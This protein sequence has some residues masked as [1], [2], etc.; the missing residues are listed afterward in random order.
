MVGSSNLK[1]NY[2]QIFKYIRIFEY[3]CEYILRIKFLF[4]FLT[5]DVKNNFH[6]RIRRICILQIIFIL[7][8]IHQTKLFATLCFGPANKARPWT[9][10]TAVLLLSA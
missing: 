9:A 5:Q 7:V 1:F 8:F 4:I 3:I 6:I 10:G 2:F